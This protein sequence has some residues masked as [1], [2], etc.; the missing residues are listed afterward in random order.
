MMGDAGFSA[1]QNARNPYIMAVDKP[2]AVLA[3]DSRVHGCSELSLSTL[4]LLRSKSG[5]SR[6]SSAIYRV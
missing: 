3:V 6:A 5:R 2:I 1:E 4:A